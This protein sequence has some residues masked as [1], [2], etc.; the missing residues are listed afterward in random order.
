MKTAILILISLLITMP[1]MTQD[2]V[3]YLYYFD[4]NESAFVIERADGT[5]R[6]LLAQGIMPDEVR[7]VAGPGWSPSGQWLAWQGIIGRVQINQA[8]FLP[9]GLNITSGQFLSQLDA[10]EETIMLH[11]HPSQ[12]WLLA[13]GLIDSTDD[14]F[15]R[16]IFRVSLIDASTDIAIAA[17]DA[18]RVPQV[19]Y[20]QPDGV[21]LTQWYE[22]STEFLRLNRDGVT[23]L[24]R[25]ATNVSISPKGHLLYNF[26]NGGWAVENLNTRQTAL[27]EGEF[28]SLHNVEW[29]GSRAL[30]VED[31]L[32]LLDAGINSI[33]P[34]APEIKIRI[35]F[36]S[37][38][39]FK[40]LGN[41]EGLW[42]P[43]GQHLAYMTPSGELMISDG[44]TSKKL[45]DSVVEW[46]WAGAET[47]LL[48]LNDVTNPEFMQ[49]SIDGEHESAKINYGRHVVWYSPDES[50]AAGFENPGPWIMNFA[51]NE[52]LQLPRSESIG[53][54]A[55]YG[56]EMLWHEAGEWLIIKE[57]PF[58]PMMGDDPVLNTVI[59]VD[60]DMRRQLPNCFVLC[61]EWL[62]E[63]VNIQSL[64]E[65]D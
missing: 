43:D 10:F 24:E 59:R 63:R 15:G 17:Y 41:V 4:P 11:W 60:G 61:V 64:P 35:G 13:V 22:D 37:G 51:S 16:Q 33:T 19:P 1:V 26:G 46:G 36:R 50:H 49:L 5:D 39:G 3:P 23:R 44:V 53:S 27:L 47:I 65:S 54:T 56:G 6:H 57:T 32:W 55:D 31:G 42:S 52:L 40:R 28:T 7:Y 45:I 25:Q 38:A 2:D 9:Y 48:A 29:N 30:I 20:W 62:P 58:V 14:G 34:I 21:I 18:E 12:D 8:T